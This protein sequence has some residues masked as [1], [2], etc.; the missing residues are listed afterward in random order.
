MGENDADSY[1]KSAKNLAEKALGPAAEAF[2]T[3][4]APLGKKAGALTVRVGDLL[5][6][7]MASLVYGMEKSADWIENAVSE[8][9]KDIPEEKIVAPTPRIAVPTL[10]ALTYSLQ[11]ESIR[12]MFANLLAADMNAD[13]K[14]RVHPA[15]VE[16]I[17]E[18]TPGDARTLKVLS[19]QN[20]VEFRVRVRSGSQ[21]Q[22]VGHDF[23]FSI[24]GLNEYALKKILSNLKRLELI[25]TRPNEWPLLENLA[26]EEE[27]VTKRF[28]PA[29]NSMRSLPAEVRAQVHLP[30][31]LSLEVFKTGLY[32]TP[33]GIDFAQVCLKDKP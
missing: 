4:V 17:R 16:M 19:K 15:F 31:E 7:A 21:F 14:E 24:D 29:F 3:E 2:G 23:T 6:R 30:G 18:M 13:T 11:D 33:M 27:R 20:Q 8:R 9:L 28:T 25:E 10:Q 32:M 26:T 12:E 22:E 5:I 1:A